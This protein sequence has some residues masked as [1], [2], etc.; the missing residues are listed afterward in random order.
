MK[1]EKPKETKNK[2]END[3]V[4]YKVHD[5]DDNKPKE[6]PYM[7]RPAKFKNNMRSHFKHQSLK[8]RIQLQE[9]TIKGKNESQ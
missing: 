8:F 6:K 9:R 7:P 5:Y 1:E 2:D 3:I 4:P